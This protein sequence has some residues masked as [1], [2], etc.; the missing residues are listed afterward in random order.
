MNT[1]ERISALLDKI[2]AAPMP[3]VKPGRSAAVRDARMAQLRHKARVGRVKLVLAP[4][5]PE[6]D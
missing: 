1:I 4:G 2:L 3:R 6:A 5:N